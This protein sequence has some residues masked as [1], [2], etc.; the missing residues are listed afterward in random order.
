MH[1]EHVL[2]WNKKSKN[3][4]Y[5]QLMLQEIHGL[6]LTLKKKLIEKDLEVSLNLAHKTNNFQI[7]PGVPKNVTNFK[8]S[9]TIR[10][11]LRNQ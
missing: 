9:S 2:A 11:K 4:I 3:R 7:L 10:F 1:N 8:T 5:L 6:F